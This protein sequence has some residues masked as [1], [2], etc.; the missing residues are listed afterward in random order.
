MNL[1]Y[2]LSILI[3]FSCR[4]FVTTGYLLLSFLNKLQTI[5]VYRKPQIQPDSTSQFTMLTCLWILVLING[6]P[7]EI[8]SS[9]S[10]AD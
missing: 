4:H 9:V 3:K 7:L 2:I 8:P 5:V 10:S 6:H 1:D